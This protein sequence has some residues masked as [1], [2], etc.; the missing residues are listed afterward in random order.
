[1]ACKSDYL[2]DFDEINFRYN[3]DLA[4]PVGKALYNF[5]DLIEDLDS[6]VIVSENNENVVV[7]SIIDTLDPEFIR[8]YIEFEDQFFEGDLT[9]PNDILIPEPIEIIVSQDN[10][11]EVETQNNALVDSVEIREGVINISARNTTS[12]RANIQF[13]FWSLTENTGDTIEVLL[14]NVSGGQFVSDQIDLSG[15]LLNLTDGGTSTNTFTYEVTLS[16]FTEGTP[17]LAGQGVEYDVNTTDFQ[18]EAAYG[19]MGNYEVSVNPDPVEVDFFENFLAGSYYFAEPYVNLSISTN[20]GVEAEFIIDDFTAFDADGFPVAS[21]EGKII[22]NPPRLEGPSLEE[23]GSFID[24]NILIDVNN[25]NIDEIVSSFATLYEISATVATNP[26]MDPTARNFAT[27][28][29]VFETIY[30]IGIPA[31][32]NMDSLVLD[33]AIEWDDLDTEDAESITLFLDTRNEFPM[34]S[35]M[36]GVFVDDFGNP[37]DFLFDDFTQIVGPAPVN[38][39]GFSTGEETALTEVLLDRA[40]L[41]R[42]N[43]A[44]ELRLLL[45]L[46]T[47]DIANDQLIKIT[48]ENEIDIDVRALIEVNT[49]TSN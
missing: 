48:P 15:A 18:Y 46:N 27:Y 16:V 4:I 42:I 32:F 39:Q 40:K 31:H 10:S 6:T 12:S 3:A 44:A 34:G 23:F 8:D 45:I 13:S 36:Q 26:D 19:Y 24:N 5:E 14:E 41:D 30:E 37:L 7:F 20:V 1:M 22:N 2:E 33:E 11:Y 17:I 29:G 38:A 47:T 25:S 21:L 9:F 43:G 35:F 28:D 49:D